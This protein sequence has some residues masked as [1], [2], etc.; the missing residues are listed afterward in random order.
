MSTDEAHQRTKTAWRAIDWNNVLTGIVTADKYFMRSGLI[1]KDILPQ[2][3][4]EFMPL[5][6]VLGNENDVENAE[7]ALHREDGDSLWLLKP[8]DSSNANGIQVLRA[9]SVASGVLSKSTDLR[10][11]HVLQRYVNPMLSPQGR[12]FHVRALVLATGNVQVRIHRELRVLQA[13]HS[14]CPTAIEDPL[15]HF[16]N[17]SVN[18]EAPGYDASSQNQ[19]LEEFAASFAMWPLCQ[20]REW[21]TSL[22]RSIHHIITKVFERL[23]ETNGRHFFALPNC[24]ELFGAD[25]MVD[26]SPEHRVWLLEVNPDPSL[27]L[28]PPCYQQQLGRVLA[29]QGLA[30]DHSSQVWNFGDP[31]LCKAFPIVYASTA[32]SGQDNNDNTS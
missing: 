31:E 22:R 18:C 2:Y 3:V 21:S 6:I 9:S 14:Y 24:Y 15:V 30:F 8:A 26:G 5:T 29:E 20:Q 13:T 4:R 1:R 25:F 16:T 11:K 32:H 23:S 27:E 12:K 28:Y 17:R 19:S 7:Q 10:R